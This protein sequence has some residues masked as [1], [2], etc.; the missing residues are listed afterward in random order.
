MA[1]KKKVVQVRAKVDHTQP[2]T[3]FYRVAGEKFSHQGEV[4][5]HV[6]LVKSGGEEAEAE[7]VL[8]NED[9]GDVIE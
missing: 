8:E 3:H 6:E 9:G 7:D 4:Y 1:T 5:E 2:G